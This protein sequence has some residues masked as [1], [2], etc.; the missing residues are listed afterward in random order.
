M[1]LLGYDIGSSSVKAGLVDAESGKCV[2]SAFYPK[3]EA[4]ILSVKLGW[5]EQNPESWWE[6]LKQATQA[7][8]AESKVANEEIK[9]IGISYQMHGL[10]CVDK[11]HRVLRPAII[12]CDS[13]AVSYGQKAFEELGHE[14]CLL[15][16]LNSPGNFT[17]S[18]LAWVKENEKQ[19]YEQ[20]DKIMLPGDYIAMRLSDEVCTTVSGLSE[21]M[22]WDF[23]Q[24][25]LAGFLLDYYGIDSSLIAEVKPTFSEQ[26]YVSAAAARE[27]GLKEGTLITYRAGDQPNNALS[28]NVFN[29]GE[30][31][32][33][34]GTSGVVYGINGVVNYD[35]K[36]RVNTFAHV[37]HSPEQPRL[38]VLL[39]INGTGIL[40]SWVKRNVAGE[41][42]YEAMNDWAGQVPI[43][44][45]GV[46]VLPFGNGVERML[47]NREVG[48]SMSGLNFNRH[49]KRHIIRAAQEGIV[50]SFKY[51]IDIMSQMGI[52]VHK[53]HAGYTNMFLSPIFRNTLAGVTG[54][55]IELYDTDG[56][57][58]AAKGA[59]MG[60]GLYKDHNE[61]FATLKKL[62]VIEPDVRHKEQYQAAY[63]LWKERLEKI[64]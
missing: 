53:I 13:R 23:Q 31:A 5:A 17:A 27:L 51:G 44:S 10:V 6:Y 7:V 62:Q 28:L 60:L 24:N 20:I 63:A 19:V 48:C 47:E 29:P 58:G 39:C 22:L 11:R 1:Y 33:T 38:G 64:L 12:W 50:F 46:C 26:G 56:S 54:A 49:D 37:N 8:L 18:K 15:H 3:R 25:T 21:G 34:A 14:R 36:S 9:A 52:S 30:I 40:N 32:S 57:V 43:G 2:A 35:L 41:I 42:S 4:P 61:A 45:E 16:L 59:G 55:T